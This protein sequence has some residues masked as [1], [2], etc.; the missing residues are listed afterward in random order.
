MPR[1]RR[2]E[3]AQATDE[4]APDFDD[5]MGADAAVFSSGQLAAMVAAI[6]RS[7]TEAFER[8]LERVIR[9]PPSPTPA[10]TPAFAAGSGTFTHCTARFSGDAGDSV[11]AFIDGIQ[12]YKDCA[13]VFEEN[14]LRGLSMVLTHNAAVWYQG[15]KK[16][17]TTWD[18]VI[19]LLQILT[20]INDLHTA[21][22]ESCSTRNKATRIPTCLSRDAVHYLQRFPSAIFPKERKSIWFMAYSIQEYVSKRL[23]REEFENFSG[24]LRLAR[25]IEIEEEVGTQTHQ[26]SGPPLRG[27]PRPTAYDGRRASST[28]RAPTGSSAHAGA[29]PTPAASAASSSRHSVDVTADS[30]QRSNKKLRCV[31]CK[32]YGHVREE[33]K[34]LQK[35]G[36]SDNSDKSSG[37]LIC[38]G[39]GARGFMRSQCPTCNSNVSFAS[40][41]FNDSSGSVNVKLAD[42]VVHPHEVLVATVNVTITVDRSVRVDFMIFPDADNN[43]TLLGIDFLNAA[44]SSMTLR[45][46]EGLSLTQNQRQQLTELLQRHEDIF[47]LGGEAT[48]FAEHHID[49][50]DHAPIAV[51]PYRLTPAKRS[52]MEAE[53]N[54]MLKDGVIEEC[55]SAWAAPALLIPKKDGTYRFCVDYQR[56]NAIT[57]S[58]TYPLPVIE[59]LLHSTKREGYM[60]TLDLRS[61]YWQ[62]SVAPADRDKTSFISPMGVFRFLRM[63][64]GL[65]NAP[66]TFQRLMDRF[67]SGST[68]KDVT[69]LIY[70]DDL[71]ILSD[72]P[73]QKHL[74]DLDAIFNRLRLF[75]LRANR[76]KCNFACEQVKYLGHL[77]THKGILPDESKVHAIQEMKE[78]SNLKHLKSFL[79]TCSWFRKF[80]PGF[81]EIAQPLTKLTKKNE[82]WV[83]ADDQRSAFNELK[84]R[85]ITAPVLV[86]ADHSK[87]FI[88]HTDAS[89]YALGAVLLQ[90][91]GNDV[92]PIEYSSRLLTFHSNKPAGL[93]QTPILHQR[94]EVLAVDLFGPLP[95]AEN[96]KKWV[97][98]IEDTA[99]RWVELFALKEATAENL[100]PLYHP[101]ANP[102][103]RKNR[104]LKVQ[105][106]MLVKNEHRSWP[107]FLPQDIRDRVE[108]HQDQKKDH[109]DSSR[110]PSPVFKVGD[111]VLLTM[112]AL[113]NA[114]KGLTRKFMPQR[115]GSY[116]INKGVVLILFLHNLPA[117][118]DN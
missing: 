110:R 9:Q 13:N 3:A 40:L 72:G 118:S 41:T 6:Q 14:A 103:E 7:Q 2:E 100:I 116:T 11:E 20:A 39:C 86:Q 68:L 4:V 50:G 1:T 23:R 53:I 85:L 16:E 27:R 55:E 107:Q 101:E 98:L 47:Q 95:E 92:H 65:K 57:K 32:K 115:D 60:S 77:I 87:P 59:D 62:V 113:S 30:N 108:K 58:D 21:S 8:L 38:Y 29:T 25:S 76:E 117:G 114:T 15:I 105:L 96:G 34:K 70:L 112:R 84:K 99:T 48:R 5:A 90:G 67:R 26:Q 35:C 97:F 28:A 33:C 45:A 63:P 89:N 82:P 36:D 106:A 102:A 64:F 109:G 79:Q 73:F 12:S 42:G 91:E 94:G 81:S 19:E 69:L 17:I 24:M 88:I 49:T 46:D 37:S 51:P 10:S 104:D 56:L 83:W 93:L 54:K 18:G 111:Q 44:V 66:A 61:G 80:V 75:G 71:L 43:D 22:T 31:Y 74:E 52:I 78:P